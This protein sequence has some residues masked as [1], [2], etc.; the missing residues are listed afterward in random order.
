MKILCVI[1]SLGSGGAQRQMVNLACGLKS[2]GHDLEILI[3]HPELSFFRSKI[4]NARIPII[5]IYKGKG[6]SIK[7]L[8]SLI[9]QLRRGRYDGVI[10][11][12]YAPNI[13]IELA[14]FSVR[15]VKLIVSERTNSS[16]G[17]GKLSSWVRRRLHHLATFVVT[18]SEVSSNWLRQYKWLK[19][20]TR[21]IY[22][23][24]DTSGAVI[25]DSTETT[26]MTRYLVLAR[27][28]TGK[29][30]LRLLKALIEYKKKHD[31]CLRIL[32]A[33]RQETDEQTLSELAE[34]QSLFLRNPAIADNWFWLGEQ[35]DVPSLLAS[36][37][38]LLHPSLYEGMPNSVC[39]A[40][41]AGRPVIASSVS[42][43]PYLVKDGVRGI[44]CDPLSSASI[45]SALER[46]ELM[47]EL[48]RLN[49]AY[50]ARLFAEE[51]LSIDRMVDKYEELLL[52]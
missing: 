8:L 52:S 34:M 1:D 3:Y 33:G 44:L 49:L 41:I 12:L 19:H 5:E 10:S 43:L 42:D 11:F 40:F 9:M 37:D 36:C 45:C 20:K 30:P 32:W 23:G 15:P 16:L 28:H 46:F 25:P 24:Y 48:Q 2:R 22:N 4:V 47:T 7:L 35:G 29:N 38:A 6:F 27:V 14:R 18:N 51:Y 31:K 17:S 39:E 26:A 21:T 13:Y 50:N